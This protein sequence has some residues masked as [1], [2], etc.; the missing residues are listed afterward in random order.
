MYFVCRF[1]RVVEA[2]IVQSRYIAHL[3]PYSAFVAL[4]NLRYI[5]ALNNN[6]NKVQLTS[7]LIGL[8]YI[9]NDVIRPTPMP[10]G[11]QNIVMGVS[12]ILHS[13][14]WN[15]MYKLHRIFCA[16]YPWPWLGLSLVAL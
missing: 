6:N 4:A 16:C 2:Y 11:K 14:L 10:A 5:N 9:Q 15:S 1:T 12:V 8:Q 13:C 3:W 7:V